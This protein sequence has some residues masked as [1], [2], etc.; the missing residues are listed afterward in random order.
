MGIPELQQV[1]VSPLL[2]ELIQNFAEVNQSP[3]QMLDCNFGVV[4]DIL[5]AD[6]VRETKQRSATEEVRCNVLAR[7]LSGG[8]APLGLSGAPFGS[9]WNAIMHHLGSK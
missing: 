4:L 8:A 6:S 7:L 1:L 5:E 2:P 3:G 9:Q